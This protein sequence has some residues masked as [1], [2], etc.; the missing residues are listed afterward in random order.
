[1]K[2]TKNVKFVLPGKEPPKDKKVNLF[3]DVK[4]FEEYAQIYA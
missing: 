2:K 4:Y 3:K 1:M